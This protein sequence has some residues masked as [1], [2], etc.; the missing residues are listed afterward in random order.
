[1][2]PNL[3]ANEPEFRGLRGNM[4]QFYAHRLSLATRGGKTSRRDW[5][6]YLAFQRRV[7]C[8]QAPRVPKDDWPT[9]DGFQ[10]SPAGLG[11]N[12]TLFPALKRRV[13]SDV[14]RSKLERGV[15]GKTRTG[16]DFSS[17]IQSRA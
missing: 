7:A 6:E 11:H 9:G 13:F 14:L 16:Q 1:M 12:L 2:E 17:R 15:V 4:G 3:P 5:R 8:E 10:P